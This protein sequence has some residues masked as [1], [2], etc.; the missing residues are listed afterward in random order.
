[1]RRIAA[2][3]MAIPK[4]SILLREQVLPKTLVF[5]QNYY[6]LAT[7]AITGKCKIVI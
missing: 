2:V 5:E 4:V 6:W 7:N 3:K 1:M